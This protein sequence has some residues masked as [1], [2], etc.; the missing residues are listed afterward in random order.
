[1]YSLSMQPIAG[2][3]KFPLQIRQISQNVFLYKMPH[4]SLLRCAQWALKLIF[5]TGERRTLNQ[6]KVFFT[7]IDEH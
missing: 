4:F 7:F 3:C 5:S 1:M 2:T 6:G